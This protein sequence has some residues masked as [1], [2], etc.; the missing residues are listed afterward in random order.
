MNQRNKGFKSIDYFMSRQWNKIYP[1]LPTKTTLVNSF[2]VYSKYTWAFFSA[3]NLL[4]VRQ[5]SLPIS[6]YIE[7]FN[8]IYFAAALQLQIFKNNLII[9][10]FHYLYA[11][12]S[13]Y[14]QQVVDFLLVYLYITHPQK[15]LLAGTFSVEPV[16]KVVD[17]TGN[18][19]LCLLG[20]S[21]LNGEALPRLILPEGK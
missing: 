9:L 15:Y 16:A 18:S 8:V 2:N 6:E 5:P 19:S 13:L 7:W 20:I 3:A 17:W 10:P 4:C 14:W 21:T 1:S 12:C 11:S